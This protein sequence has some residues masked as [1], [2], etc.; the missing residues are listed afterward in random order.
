M[1][2]SNH[3][4]SW[5]QSYNFTCKKRKPP[6]PQKKTHP[7]TLHTTPPPFLFI[8]ISWSMNNHHTCIYILEYFFRFPILLL[9]N[10]FHS[11]PDMTTKYKH[12]LYS[13]LCLSGCLGYE[14]SSALRSNQKSFTARNVR[15]CYY[16]SDNAKVF[17][18]GNMLIR[19]TRKY[20]PMCVIYNT[21]TIKAQVYWC[22]YFTLN[23]FFFTRNMSVHAWLVIFS[24]W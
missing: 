10:I 7:T 13:V 2:E 17:F 19:F 16:I 11:T 23:I 15:Y 21:I 14:S 6:P 4:N 18:I 22:Q 3:F 1:Y 9:N 20:Q 24:A 5:Q 12:W 8:H